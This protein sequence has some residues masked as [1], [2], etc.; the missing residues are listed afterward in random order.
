MRCPKCGH[1]DDKVIDS[2]ASKDGDSIRRRRECLKCAHRF[3]TYEEVE[4]NEFFVMKR[5]GRR[6]KFDRAKVAK[7][8]AIAC[9][10][11]PVSIERIE[12]IV[13]QILEEITTRYER[14][15]TSSVVGEK[16]MEK[17][18]GLDEV[19]YVR[20][21]SV[22]RSFRDVNEFVSEVNSLVSQANK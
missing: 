18:K 3:T 22:Y 8:I 10:K 16:I 20:F 13:D 9:Q 17:L 2:R 11:R 6:E 15:V 7:S 4:R 5:D 14:E 1:Q 19:A 12:Q 21:A